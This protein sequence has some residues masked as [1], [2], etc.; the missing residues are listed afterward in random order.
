MRKIN[1]HYISAGYFRGFIKEIQRLRY[2]I[3]V[4]DAVEILMN[5]NQILHVHESEL[6]D[7]CD[8]L[9]DS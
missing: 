6:L 5:N 4:A 2:S 8:M 7:I 3:D 9:A 1:E